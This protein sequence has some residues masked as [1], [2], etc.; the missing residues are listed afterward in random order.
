MRALV[1]TKKGVGHLDI[2]DVPEPTPGLKQVKAEIKYCGI[3]GTDLKIY[4]NEHSYYD[5]PSIL[6]HEYS[7]VVVEVGEDVKGI[8]VGEEIVGPLRRSNYQG[9][10]RHAYHVPG[11]VRH[12]F[13]SPWGVVASGAF[14]KYCVLDEHVVHKIP[15]GVDLI[16]AAFSEPIAVCARTIIEFGTVHCADVAVVSGPGSIGLLAAQ[17]AK[18]EGATVIVC[19][20]DGDEK[21]LELALEVGA[22]MVFN[23]SR[24]DPLPAIL[25]LTKGA[26][27]DVVIECAGHGASVSNLLNFA[28]LGAQYIQIGTSAHTYEIDFMQL[29]YKELKAVGSL[30]T[31]YFTWERA[32]RLLSNGQVNPAPLATHTMPLS[33]WKEAFKVIE[34][35]EAIKIL[36]YPD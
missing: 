35:G 28:R 26:G 24:E 1:K 5:C 21:K 16:S 25:D 2:Y 11:A 20:I 19:G 7:A 29:A 27:A 3:C 32:L 30:G 18:A 33:R 8:E 9:L 22:D 6:G 34:A 17:I 14:A 23:V 31:S 10:R 12:G 13:D 4:A 36:L 15:E